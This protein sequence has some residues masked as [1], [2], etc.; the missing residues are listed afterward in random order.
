MAE[1]GKYLYCII[2]TN[3]A[4]NFG[5]LGIGGRGDPVTTISHDELS[6]VIS[7]APIKK[8]T[9]TRENTIAHEKAI[10]EVMRQG[11]T[12]LPVRFGTVAGSAQEVRDVLRKRYREFKDLLHDMDNKVE[13]G[14]KALWLDMQAIFNEILKER[15]DIKRLRDRAARKPTRD[16]MIRVGELVKEALE[17]RKEREAA[18]IFKSLNQVAADSKINKPFGDNMFLNAAF[19]VDRSR[20]KEF[21]TEI[22]ALRSQYEGRAKITYVGPAPPFNSVNIV[23]HWEGREYANYLSN[24]YFG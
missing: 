16:S 21:D 9:T 13:L 15:Q 11:Y 23:I 2:G 4:R 24:T 10:E 17:R 8:Y 19:L 22:E 5:P 1:E 14:V 18:S 7:D 20:E 3:Q 12:V 6:A